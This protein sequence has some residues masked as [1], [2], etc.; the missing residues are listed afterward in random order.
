MGKLRVH[1]LAKELG[2]EN[3][4]IIET[5]SEMGVPVTSHMS[6]IEDNDCEKIRSSRYGSKTEKEKYYSGIPPPEQ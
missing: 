6:T 5:L 3:K 2:K 1:E 4:D